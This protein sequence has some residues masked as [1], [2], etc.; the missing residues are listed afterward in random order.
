MGKEWR[1]PGRDSSFWP[2]EE[3]S[4]LRPG[5]EQCQREAEPVLTLFSCRFPSSLTSD[6]SL[7]MGSEPDAHFQGSD[8]RGDSSFLSQF[9]VLNRRV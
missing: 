9:D 4:W 6:F 5:Q 3:G 7:S 1:R 2:D 8:E